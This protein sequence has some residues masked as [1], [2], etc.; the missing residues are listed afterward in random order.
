MKQ[1]RRT[2]VALQKFKKAVS[3]LPSE[4]KAMLGFV[5][6]IGGSD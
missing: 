5:L 1:N 4:E 2:F 6:P 3:F